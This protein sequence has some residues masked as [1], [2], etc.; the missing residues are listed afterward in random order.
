MCNSINK[1]DLLI[2]TSND[3]YVLILENDKLKKEI[4]HYSDWLKIHK[5]NYPEDDYWSN[6]V[7]IAQI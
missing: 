4:T 7:K 5:F 2:S 1:G 3:L 6:L